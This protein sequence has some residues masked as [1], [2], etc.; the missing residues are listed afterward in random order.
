MNPYSRASAQELKTRPLLAFTYGSA[1]RDTTARPMY[2]GDSETMK[3]LGA[4][5][6]LPL[7]LSLFFDFFTTSFQLPR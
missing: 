7:F 2:L 5:F 3:S 4:S 6:W 1:A